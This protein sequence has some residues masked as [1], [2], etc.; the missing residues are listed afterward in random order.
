MTD[1]TTAK[2]AP[3]G[4]ALHELLDAPSV[5]APLAVDRSLWGFGG[6]HGGLVLALATAAMR[7]PAL[8]ALRSVT[9]HFLR[10]VRG[11]LTIETSDV[12]VG[13]TAQVVSATVSSAGRAALVATSTH[14]GV[15]ASS[16]PIAPAAPEAPP[17]M[18]CD[19]FELPT[20]IVPF[21]AHTEI[22]PA[23]PSRPFGGG[24][25]AE[26]TAWIRLRGDDAPVD[27]A[28]LIVLVDALAPSYTATLRELVLVPTIEL[29]VRPG[30]G[31]ADASSPW[32]LVRARSTAASEDGWIEESIDAWTPQGAHLGSA[33]Q[34]R[35]A[36][37]PR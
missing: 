9:G 3:A 27:E 37:E 5:P 24:D 28:R 1:T 25:V 35:L 29:T 21:A 18:D 36:V 26:L 22:R 20:E 15:A 10:P 33:R 12:R 4:A 32:A 34:L 11:D 17:P 30:T 7:S 19:V 6:V 14:G 16:A 2:E 8:N 31:L 23:T 13:R